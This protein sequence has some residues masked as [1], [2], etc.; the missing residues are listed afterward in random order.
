M[1]KIVI[2][3]LSAGT[4]YLLNTLADYAPTRYRRSD[5]ISEMLRCA[6]ELAERDGYAEDLVSIST[7]DEL[8]SP[9]ATRLRIPDHVAG[10]ISRIGVSAGISDSRVVDYLAAQYIAELVGDLARREI[11]AEI[12][13]GNVLGTAGSTPTVGVG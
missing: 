3:R 12:G 9:Y 2:Y 6:V 8:Q 4:T 5:V 13:A 10:A 7:A 11:L 1:T